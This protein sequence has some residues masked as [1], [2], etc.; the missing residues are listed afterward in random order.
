MPV[1]LGAAAF[2]QIGLVSHPVRI[3][4]TDVRARIGGPDL[5]H[6]PLHRLPDPWRCGASVVDGE[7]DEHQVRPMLQPGDLVLSLGAGNIVKAGEDLLSILQQER[8]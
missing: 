6:D 4:E 5:P 8:S 1:G 2:R 7:F 3:G